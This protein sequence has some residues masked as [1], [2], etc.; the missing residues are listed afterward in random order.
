MKQ[1]GVPIRFAPEAIVYHPARRLSICRW[2]Y[3]IFQDRWH[4]LYRLKTMRAKFAVIDE[5][6]DL[7]RITVQLL[8]RGGVREA[9]GRA[10]SILLRWI[11]SHSGFSIF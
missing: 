6:K 4:L 11:F 7:A 1:L 5:G 9:R 8:F 10:L 3:R 2:I